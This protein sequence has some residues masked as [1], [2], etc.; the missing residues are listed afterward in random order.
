MLFINMYTWDIEKRD[1]I[2][3]R[4]VDNGRMTA[5]GVKVLG[6]WTAV[7]KNMG[8]MLFEAEDPKLISQS[9][10]AWSDIIKIENLLVLDTEKDLIDLL[11]G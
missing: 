3:K 7:G 10:L 4:R 5:E 1:E 9:N 2:I 11:K 8:F 6:E